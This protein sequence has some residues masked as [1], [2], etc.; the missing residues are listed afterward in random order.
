MT[1]GTNVWLK[2]CCEFEINTWSWENPQVPEIYVLT[3]DRSL[4]EYPRR[5]A[6]QSAGT[7]GTISHPQLQPSHCFL[8]SSTHL[9]SQSL[10]LSP[11]LSFQTRSIWSG[12]SQLLGV[13]GKSRE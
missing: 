2:S 5:Q 10:L 1:S 7:P 6:A 4:L 8:I 12:P 13:A 3:G 9:S 11:S